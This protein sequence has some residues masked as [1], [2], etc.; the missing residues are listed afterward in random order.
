MILDTRTVDSPLGPLTLFARDATLVGLEFGDRRDRRQAL[1]S[2][3]TRALGAFESREVDDPAGAATRLSRY[4]AGELGA[5]LEQ[6]VES[7]GTPFQLSVWGALREIPAGS[8]WTYAQLAARIGKPTAQRAVGAANGA[9]PIA[10]FVPCHRVI[11]ADGTLWGY[12]GGLPRKRWLLAH[13][14]VALFL[15]GAQVS[16]GLESVD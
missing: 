2:H 10:L 5:L 11:A 12:G 4:F 8:T 9:N 1:A 15:D 7:P 14:G 13:E 6:P 16:L 3:L